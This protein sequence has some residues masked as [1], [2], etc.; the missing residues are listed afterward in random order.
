MIITINAT[1]TVKII[2]AV[3]CDDCLQTNSPG[4]LEK[5]GKNVIKLIFFRTLHEYHLV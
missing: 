4:V 5:K 1:N 2:L 3:G